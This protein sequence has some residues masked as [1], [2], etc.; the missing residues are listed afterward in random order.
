MSILTE[1]RQKS[2]IRWLVILSLLALVVFLPM[3]Y[4]MVH[5]HP[6]NDYRDHIQFARQYADGQAMPEHI[7]AHPAWQFSIVLLSRVL[8]I[9]LE[10][11][12]VILQTGLDVL[13]VWLLYV[14]LRTS[15]PELRARWAALLS[16]GVSAAAPLMIISISDELFYLG[17]VGITSYHNPTIIML[18]PLAV[19]VFLFSVKLVEGKRFPVWQIALS[20][21]IVVLSALAKPNLLICLL[22]AAAILLFIRLIRRESF[23]W[24]YAILGLILPA[25]M[26][27][28]WQFLATFGAEEG[29]IQL[30]PLA[31]M[32][33]YSGALL[34]KFILSIWFPLTVFVFFRKAIWRDSSMLLAWITFLIGAAF[35]YLLA[36]GP[37]RFQDG[38]WGWSGEIGLFLLFAAS[39]VYFLM[40]KS[41]LTPKQV[42]LILWGG[43]APHVLAGIVYYVYVIAGKTFV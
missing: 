13:L 17:Y 41:K 27:L 18:R 14:K 28:G 6:H 42:N 38:N 23:D 2:S 24:W 39:M 40:N 35:T 33:E 20:A 36:E 21:L 7:A 30:A 1:L 29:G 9:G 12:A 34:F 26:V 25:V 32:K 16:L 22:P 37:A 10:N 43:Y 31:V 4:H 19:I 5:E 3:N 8:S 15:A 11:A